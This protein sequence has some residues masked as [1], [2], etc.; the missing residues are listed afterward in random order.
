MITLHGKEPFHTASQKARLDLRI[1]Y[2]I[3]SVIFRLKLW[4]KKEEA[5]FDFL[6][7]RV[8]LDG[9]ERSYP[10]LRT[11]CYSSST[12]CKVLSCR[13]K[14]E[15]LVTSFSSHFLSSAVSLLVLAFSLT[16]CIHTYIVR[17]RIHTRTYVT[18]WSTSFIAEAVL[19][20]CMHWSRLTSCCVQSVIF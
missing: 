18:S 17:T 2:C 16:L 1:F 5:Q 10:L 13:R 12:R 11:L 14:E 4:E 15:D 3:Y 19:G 20:A 6:Y 7:R 8:V 9:G